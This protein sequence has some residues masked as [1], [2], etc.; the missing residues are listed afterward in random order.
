MF[1]TGNLDFVISELH[2][3]FIFEYAYYRWVIDFL[4]KYPWVSIVYNFH[5]IFIDYCLSCV[6]NISNIPY[7]HFLS[8]ATKRSR[9]NQEEARDGARR[10]G[11][12]RRTW[13]KAESSVPSSERF[14]QMKVL[15]LYKNVIVK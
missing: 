11:S 7:P 2:W 3:V 15:L 14:V 6:S 1:Q 10:R 5:I 12:A 8:A 9:G 4:D 13:A